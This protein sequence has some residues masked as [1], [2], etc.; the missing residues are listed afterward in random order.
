MPPEQSHDPSAVGKPAD[1]YGLG[2]TLFWVLTGEL[3]YAFEINLSKALRRLREEPPRR[4]RDFKPDAP[5][6]LDLLLT[7]LLARDPAAGPPSALAG[8]DELRPFLDGESA[9]LSLGGEELPERRVLIVDDEAEIRRMH[10]AVLEQLGCTC[11][12]AKD[13]AAALDEADRRTF[14]LVLLDLQLPDGNGYD[15]CRRLRQSAA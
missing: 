2:A 4:L 1:I 9:P 8:M 10:R 7:R 3:P 5:P 14:D 12:E 13:A 6:A 11:V 15:V